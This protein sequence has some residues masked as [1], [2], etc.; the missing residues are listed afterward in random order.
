MKRLYT[1]LIAVALVASSCQKDSGGAPDTPDVPG[2]IPADFSWKTTRDVSVSVAAP[3][4]N[5]ATPAYAVISVYS[6]PILSAE[7]LV[8]KG[9]TKSATPFRSAFTLPAGVE[10][11][12][13]VT[14][15][16]DGTKSVKMA[17]AR[18]TVDVS[19]ASMTTA[20]MPKIRAAAVTRSASSMPAF[21][22]MT[23]PDAGSFDPQAVIAAT[24]SKNFNLGARES[25]YA[26]AAY[27]IPA[28]AVIEGN[29]NLNGNYAPH[30]QPV[31]YVA[32]KLVLSSPNIGYATLAVLPGGEVTVSG[33]LSAQDV[34][35]DLPALYV[36]PGGKLTAAEV[37]FSGKI[38][39]NLGTVNVTGKLDLNNDLKFYNGAGAVLTAATFKYSNT[40]GLFND[41]AISVDELEFNSTAAFENCENGDL[42]V[43]EMVMANTTTKFYQKGI[44]TISEMTCRGEFYVN[45]Y[46]YVDDLSLEGAKL[47]IAADA[48]LEVGEA[49]FNN[50]KAEMAAGSLFIAQHYNKAQKGGNNTFT[51]K[52][53]STIPVVRFEQSAFYSEGNQWWNA[54]RTTFSGAMEVVDPNGENKFYVAKCFTDGAFLSFSQ[55]TNIPESKCNSGK[56][57]I[58]PDPEPEPEEYTNVAGQTYTYCFE[59][60]WP[61]FGDYDMNDVVIVSRIDRMM[62]KDGSKVSALTINWELRA[63]GTTY[64]IAGAV[65]MDKVQ[66]SDVANVESSHKAFGSGMF[67]SQGL[68]PDSQYAVIPFFN[69]TKELLS[70]SNTWKGHPASATQKHT[71]TVTFSQPV[72]IATVLDSEMNFFITPKQR[73]NEIHMPGYKPTAS[74]L[75]GKGS[76]QPAD[77]YKFFVT[78]GDQ[79]KNNYM[80]WALVIPGEFR[81]PA[82]S[83]DIRGVYE[84]F[85]TWASSNGTQHT[86]WYL[87]SADANKIY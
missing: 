60:N 87:E 82:E 66:A 57:Q 11:L 25:Q 83:N 9:A 71:T 70:T 67:A 85:M 38:A 53:G 2:A 1:A 48:C 86:E 44:A 32:G 56:A 33:K 65:Q 41:G 76:F 42:K 39:V 23:A 45:C 52:A 63:A 13:V 49:D 62:S 69:K 19:G 16:P 6:S 26:A 64:D 20:A 79:L 14:T 35:K 74:G 4:V 80:M 10:N 75:I 72:D 77:P 34:A 18:S 59:D 22:T 81:Y 50:S 3:T 40:G 61:W 84:H 36:F 30:K 12:Y 54:A 37:N 73:T 43:E 17:E 21:P 78:E 28:G 51:A 47:Y 7:N 46:T 27:Y 55:M 24:P 15:L 5:G 29:I 8:A 31:L 58:T 68:D